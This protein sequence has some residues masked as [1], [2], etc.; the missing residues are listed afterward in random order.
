[1][2]AL[3]LDVAARGVKLEDQRPD[4]LI[5]DDIDG[6]HDSPATTAKKIETI[7][8]SILPAG[9][10]NVAILVIQNLI[11]P[12]GVVT[13]LVDGRADYL[14]KRVLSGPHP[15]LSGMEW[16]YEDQ[17][18][19]QRLAIITAGTP[20]W[21][22][23][24]LAVCQ[25]QVHEWGIGAFL[26]E[27]QH[28]VMQ[29]REGLALSY[30]PKRHDETLTDEEC[31]TLVGMGQAIGGMDFGSWRFSFQLR[32]VG[33]AGRRPPGGR[34]F[35]AAR[36]DRGPGARHP[37]ALP[38]LR[39][40]VGRGEAGRGDQAPH[41]RRQRQPYGHRGDQRG[42]PP[43]RVAAPRGRRG[44]G[45]QA[46][47]S[48][49]GAHQRR[50]GARGAEVPGGRGPALRV[51]VGEAVGDAALRRTPADADPLE[52]RHGRR[53]PGRRDAG[54]AATVGARAL[55][56][57]VPK[58]GEVQAQVPD[59]AT[60][61][62]ADAIDADRYALMSYWKPA[63]PEPVVAVK[64]RNVDTGLEKLLARAQEEQRRLSGRGPGLS[65]KGT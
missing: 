56:L 27:A 58:P 53:Q 37:R 45:R 43:H 32:A 29:R 2:D 19:G 34:V 40:G 64:D 62:G 5:F 1:V 48:L 13:R 11:I 33:P 12:D 42:L 17:P 31:R 49:G 36:T 16:E 50:A 60:A 52:P 47:A 41:L 3:G 54:L 25:K 21:E 61:D 26:K 39:G 14:A 8:T 38:P 9:S 63:K 35:L 65:R 24:S 15:A 18:G 28:D 46:A 30:D 51:C 57:P 7:T 44:P 23:Q 55:E 20:T 22:G 59:D 6:K 10:A 4:I